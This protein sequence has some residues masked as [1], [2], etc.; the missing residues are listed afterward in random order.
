MLYHHYA[1]TPRHTPTLRH[2]KAT[3]V[4]KRAALEASAP[5]PLYSQIREALRAEIERKA[6]APGAQLPPESALMEQFGV[7]RITVR[8][9][10]AHLQ[11]DGL[12]FKVPG[13][14][15]F[16]SELNATQEINHLEGFAEAM[17]RQGRGTTNRVLSH[18]VTRCNDV[19]AAKLGIEPGSYVTE[20]RRV[21]YL[22]SRPVSLDITYLSVEI[23]EALRESAALVTRDLF[24]ILEDDMKIRLRYADLD[25]AAI[26]PDAAMREILEMRDDSPLLKIERL[27]HNA[28]NEPVDFEYLFVRTDYLHY[29]L[30]LERKRKS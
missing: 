23:G 21:R 5:A 22:D 15:T 6:L 26:S 25:I 18:T 27:T 10:L 24:S 8:Q 14:G 7:S 11:T 1:T 29:T 9:A 17:E 4:K 16:V 13:K 2:S 28:Q 3:T 20:I 30:R 19:V 12:V